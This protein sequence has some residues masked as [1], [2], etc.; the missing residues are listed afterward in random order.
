M[1]ATMAL[2]M[3]GRPDQALAAAT[4]LSDELARTGATR[5]APRPLNL[6]GWIVRNLGAVSEAD[7]LNLAALRSPGRWT[8]SNRW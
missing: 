4:M 3:V 2:A 7:E 5:W 6:R 1:G 8:W